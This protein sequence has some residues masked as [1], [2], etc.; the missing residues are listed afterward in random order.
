MK[1]IPVLS[2]NKILEI[3]NLDSKIPDSYSKY[4]GSEKFYVSFTVGNINENLI[5]LDIYAKDTLIKKESCE[6]I[7]YKE[8]SFI[9]DTE[10]KLNEFI[11]LWSLNKVKIISG[12]INLMQI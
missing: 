4:F 7:N 3:T 5:M 11:I 10:R 12:K 9:V 8:I 6:A 2:D 1:V